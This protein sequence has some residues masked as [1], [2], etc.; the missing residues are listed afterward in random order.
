MII[1]VFLATRED[2]ISIYQT[3]SDRG[4]MLKQNETGVLYQDPIDVE[5]APF[6]YS[7]TEI[8][9]KEEIVYSID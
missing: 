8:K 4:V 6:T 7:E 1:R 3:Y 9:I 5:G 2:G